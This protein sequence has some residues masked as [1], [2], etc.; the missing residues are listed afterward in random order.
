MITN[1]QYFGP[2]PHD[3]AQAGAAAVLLD[4]E[5]RLVEEAIAAGAFE[6]EIDP[7]TGSE[8]S[9]S[10]GGSGDGGFR[11]KTATTGSDH[12]SHQVRWVQ[13]PDGTW[14]EDTSKA[15]AGV[16]RY[17]PRNRL[18]EWLDTFEHGDGDNSK[19]AEYGLYREHP[20]DT[21]GWCHLTTR[22]PKSRR[23]TFKP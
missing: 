23:R 2:K 11:L 15:K 9:G 17:D 1:A 5:N 13:E 16:D 12:S 8:I 7:D 3:Q 18:D 20:E 6:R 10:K 14:H 19:L 22:A 4:A 21:P